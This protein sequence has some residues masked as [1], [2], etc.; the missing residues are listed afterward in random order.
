[1]KPALPIDAR[2]W[3]LESE[4]GYVNDPRDPG[5][6]THFGI[7]KRAYPML[8]ISRLTEDD[9]CEI[10]FRD[11]WQKAGCPDLP[12]ALALAVFDCAVNQGVHPAVALFQAAVG[13]HIDGVVGLRTVEA[14]AK[15]DPRRALL[16]YIE[17]RW[18]RYHDT[19]AAHTF[20]R[21]WT[22]RLFRLEA[23]CLDLIP[24]GAA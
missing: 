12:A 19:P 17:R 13:V 4:G 14:A 10:Y 23:V 16:G 11:Y 20:L 7:S 5:G 9:A 24:K 22:K 1:M 18:D 8:D 6:E 3:I 15:A 21:G 2:A